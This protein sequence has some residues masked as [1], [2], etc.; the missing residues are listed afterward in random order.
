MPWDESKNNPMA[1]LRAAMARMEAD[2]IGLP[3]VEAFPGFTVTRA[4]YDWLV[5]QAANDGLG[6]VEELLAIRYGC[7]PEHARIAE[8]IEPDECLA[9]A[10]CRVADRAKADQVCERIERAL[11]ETME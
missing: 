3:P 11:R 6:S 7:G 5:A 1:D 9:A 10:I 8:I 4:R 2:S